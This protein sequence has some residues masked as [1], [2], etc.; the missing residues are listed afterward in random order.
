M[1]LT[2]AIILSYSIAIAGIFAVIRF[3]HTTRFYHP[4]LFFIW[5]ALASEIINDICIR[6]FHST[7]VNS[8]IYTLIEFLLIVWLFAQWNSIYTD[9]K[10]YYTILVIGFAVWVLDNLLLYSLQHQNSIFRIFYA[11]LFVYLSIMQINKLIFSSEKNI[12]YNSQFIICIAFLIYFSY[13]ATFEIFFLVQVGWSNNFYVQLFT[14]FVFVNL[15]SNILYA[16]AVLCIPKKQ[17]FI[18]PY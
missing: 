16:F 15:F 10:F 7:E 9:K 8:N 13:K 3:K 5:T 2:I 4:F 14:I 18:L 6:F 12:V 11:I 17:K 1:T